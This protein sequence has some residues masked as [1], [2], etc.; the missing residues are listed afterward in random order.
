MFPFERTNPV[1]SWYEINAQRFAHVYRTLQ[2]SLFC[3]VPEPAFARSYDAQ[4]ENPNKPT[5][6]PQVGEREDDPAAAD[7]Q[8]PLHYNQKAHHLLLSTVSRVPFGT[9]VNPSISTPNA[10]M[11]QASAP[12]PRPKHGKVGCHPLPHQP[13]EKSKHLP[14]SLPIREEEKKSNIELHFDDCKNFR[15]KP[16]ELSPECQ[17]S[18][19]PQGFHFQGRQVNIKNPQLPFQPLGSISILFSEMVS[20]L[21]EL[22]SLSGFSYEGDD[23]KNMCGRESE[24]LIPTHQKG[25]NTFRRLIHP[26]K[27]ELG[28]SRLLQVHPLYHVERYTLQMDSKTRLHRQRS[29]SSPAIVHSP[30]RHQSC[31]SLSNDSST[32]E[33]VN[34]SQ[35]MLLPFVSF[36]E[37][38]HAFFLATLLQ[39]GVT[40]YSSTNNE[41]AS[42]VRTLPLLADVASRK[43]QTSK[44]HL[45]RGTLSSMFRPGTF[46]SN[47][48]H[49]GDSEP[50]FANLIGELNTYVQ[51]HVLQVESFYNGGFF[52]NQSRFKTFMIFIQRLFEDLC[53]FHAR[54]L[55]ESDAYKRFLRSQWCDGTRRSDVCL[56]F[57]R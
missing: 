13:Q 8:T 10:R 44:S 36:E 47:S 15:Q 38:L 46:S 41:I 50:H 43:F 42:Q 40:R 45:M 2:L 55:L 7:A 48:F 16:H 17:K 33:E 53:T 49:H 30:K 57:Y 34:N 27:E 25:A 24:S 54:I 31:S 1:V 51:T 9:Q 21:C 11:F 4:C 3:A 22:I 6:H 5:D 39:S 14:P 35:I 26:I 56:G 32:V 37:R 18:D 12:I 29:S 19:P 52:L 23:D 28:F 20:S